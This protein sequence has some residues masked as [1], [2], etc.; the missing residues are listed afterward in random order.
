MATDSY[1][2]VT[3]VISSAAMRK[4]MQKVTR[5]AQSSAA[6]LITGE[7]GSGKELVARAIHHYSRRRGKAWVDV[8]CAALPEHLIESEL[9]GYERGAFSGAESLKQGLFELAHGGTLFLDEIGELDARMQVKLLR[10]VEGAP[11]YRLGG[12]R[13]VAV[14]VRIVAATSQDL[15]T[16][17]RRGGFRA[18][19]Y[20]RLAQVPIFVPAL[21]ERREDIE[22][23]AKH[24]LEQYDAGFSLT[25][26]AISALEGYHWSGN[27]RELRNVVIKAAMLAPG[28]EI[29]VSDL[30]VELR[31]QPLTSAAA[32]GFTL[33]G[34]EQQTILRV[35]AATGGHQ[36]RAADLLGI[37][38]RTLIRKLKLYGP[39][40]SNPASNTTVWD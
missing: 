39:G 10:V 18:D 15:Q 23:L 28:R 19:L 31:A 7:S 33:E 2:G 25:R 9:F 17:M 36:Q 5:V 8:N 24:F 40:A 1:L 27:I 14:D 34:M 22:P 20:H 26:E 12:V 4:L 35:L 21:R 38:R 3:A 32:A 37:S 16:A 13:K 6:V 29:D 11:Y 30:P